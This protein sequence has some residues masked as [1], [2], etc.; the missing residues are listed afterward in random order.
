MHIMESVVWEM[1]CRCKRGLRLMQ[2]CISGPWGNGSAS[3][4]D[5][6]WTPADT[7]QNTTAQI[8]KYNNANTQIHNFTN[9]RSRY[10]H[11]RDLGEWIPGQTQI[12]QQ[13]RSTNY[14]SD[15]IVNESL[16]TWWFNEF[17]FEDLL[18]CCPSLMLLEMQNYEL[19]GRFYSAT[20]RSATGSSAMPNYELVGMF[21]LGQS[22]RRFCCSDKTAGWS[23]IPAYKYRA[24]ELMV[25]TVT[26]WQWYRYTNTTI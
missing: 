10:I 15:M 9:T 3:G 23:I 22:C 24:L 7:Q 18:K 17:V 13:S 19:R 1:C 11:I 14:K 4:D 12:C 25:S 8:H 2:R 5:S 16:F 6:I 21:A 20:E 26:Q